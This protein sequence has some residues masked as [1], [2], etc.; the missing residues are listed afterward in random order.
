[1]TSYADSGVHLD[2]ADETVARI[3]P[4]VTA[5]WGN[6]V[7]GGFAGFA[8]GLKFPT[9]YTE[10]V[11][12]M[13]TDGVGTKAEIARQTDSVDGL[14]WDLVAMCID[15]IAAAGGQ[16]IAMSDYIA[17][18][19]L[20]SELVTRIV[21][22]VAQACIEADIALL[23]GEIAEH[24]GVM[25]PDA[26]DIAGTALGVV[27]ASRMIDGSR[28]EQGDVVIGIDSPNLRSNGF[29]LIRKLIAENT[30]LGATFPGTDRT[31]ADVV[32]EPSVL[33]S[34]VVQKLIDAV[35]VKGLCHVTGGG[36]IGNVPRILPGNVDV[37]IE[38]GSWIA[39]EV[40][41]VFAGW[42]GGDKHDWYATWN[43]G[44]GF[45]LFVSPQDVSTTISTISSL[46]RS[47]AAIGVTTPGS[48]AVSL[49]W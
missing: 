25:E 29:S 37:I 32:L 46:G 21:E 13:S 39:P 18:G 31:V 38:V 35:D 5:T 22:S 43:M 34:P 11:L 9:G 49:V 27:E 17:V 3:K 45:V 24:P 30:S 19:H 28:I 6:R 41:N 36:L 47:G 12:M 48:G 33:Y 44:I 8:A 20:R 1:M 40:F 2:A 14:G 23:G 10:P 15:D 16:P 26:F 4:A 42:S 7:V